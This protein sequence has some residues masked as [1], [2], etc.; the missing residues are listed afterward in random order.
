MRYLLSLFLLSVLLQN[1]ITSQ[2][3]L[4][5]MA[6]ASI[7]LRNLVKYKRNQMRKLQANT[8]IVPDDILNTLPTN[9]P[10]HIGSDAEAT[11]ADD[12]VPY[13]SENDVI[14]PSDLPITNE[15]NSS[16]S[17]TSK[18]NIIQ[19]R[20]FHGFEKKLRILKFGVLLYFLNR[21]I[22]RTVVIRIT[23]KYKSNGRNIRR[24][25]DENLAGE[26]VRT[27]CQI[28]E[29]YEEYVDQVGNG[30][31]VDYNC[32]AA[33]SS[34]ADIDVAKIDDKLPMIVGN[35]SVPLDEIEFHEDSE[36]GTKNLVN[37]NST[38]EMFTLNGTIWEPAP[39]NKF[40][41]KGNLIPVP[42]PEL[43]KGDDDIDID[44]YDTSI[45]E[46]KKIQCIVQT[47]EKKSGECTIECNT[48]ETPLETNYGNLTLSSHDDNEK[49]L[50][51]NIREGADRNALIKAGPV[52]KNTYYRKKS[53]G[54]SGGAIAG[55]V[56]AC[57]VVVAAASIAA[58]MLKKPSQPEDNTTVVG[59]K[60]I[61]NI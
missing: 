10:K 36:D 5:R 12:P 19:V 51:I 46:K 15:K 52:N 27:V 37:A 43:L 25:D 26:S 8:D 2:D 60:T 16:T 11:L 42:K 41:L 39:D 17:T 1:I 49:Y 40:L 58:I 4:D 61:E 54:L 32:N 6:R 24:L 34:T 53:S 38:Q 55:I 9:I 22:V 33:T 31:N 21:P 18:P 57:F 29:D 35:E 30:N 23:I 56:I 13:Q 44:F 3:I 28:K 14:L 47:L 7:T 48:S 50:S 45:G 20:K 59:L